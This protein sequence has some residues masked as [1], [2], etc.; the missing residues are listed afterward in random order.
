MT[1][2]PPSPRARHAAVTLIDD[3]LSRE[4]A[5]NPAIAG[6]EPGGTDECRW[7]VRLRGDEKASFAVWFTLGQRTLRYETYMSPSPAQNREA[8]FEYLLA[9]NH[10]FYGAAFE[11][12]EEDGIFLA[13]QLAIEAITEADLDRALGSLYA[14]TEAT[15][16]AILRIGFGRPPRPAQ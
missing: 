15:F 2:P 11:I 4:A 12:G 8:V 13:G 10:K 7:I 14:Y 6:V 5:E 1:I 3:W 9:R 16:P